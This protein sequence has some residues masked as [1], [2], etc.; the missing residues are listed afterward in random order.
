MLLGGRRETFTSGKAA[1]AAAA[2]V[3]VLV[4]SVSQL[5]V[6]ASTDSPSEENCLVFMQNV[7]Q[8]DL[9]KYN[10]TLVVHLGEDDYPEDFPKN[11]VTTES[12]TYELENNDSKLQVSFMFKNGILSWCKLYVIDGEPLFKESM[13]SNLL[14]RMKAFV[15]SCD[16]MKD[17]AY[18]QRMVDML[19]SVT[20]LKNQ[21]ITSG[22]MTF[23]VYTEG[24][25]EFRWSYNL[26]GTDYIGKRV[27]I[28]F[29]N[30]FLEVL[31]DTWEIY[32]VADVSIKISSEQAVEIARS[33]AV[34]YKLQ[35][36]LEAG[37]VDVAFNLSDRVV[38]PELT[39]LTRDSTLLY[40]FWDTEVY[41][42]KAYY[43]Y[44]GVHVGL[45]ADTGEVSYCSVLGGY[46]VGPD[47]SSEA[48]PTPTAATAQPT[49][50]TSE[51]TSTPTTTTTPTA[52][53]TSPS[54]L[55]STPTTQLTTLSASAASSVSSV[56]LPMD[57]VYVS[58][59]VIA[60]AVA[61]VAIFVYTRRKTA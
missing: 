9:E 52:E 7:L 18:T 28:C 38:E 13:P 50:T 46:F 31:S 23:G 21:E 27:G 59:T 49:Q 30:G 12:L 33:R 17:A 39:W 45:W 6:S 35:I 32:D 61:A 1:L 22:N 44:Y 20:E 57:V 51:L 34:D 25:P 54:E 37:L 2:L 42:D 10:T 48:T 4:L 55:T 24:S 56:N 14:D 26:N 3:F 60:V 58:C 43:S 5:L 47:S 8:L 53:P 11:V 40:P 19:D 16:T 36:Y 15:T 41:F 29:S